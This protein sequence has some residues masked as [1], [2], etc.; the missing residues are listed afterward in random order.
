MFLELNDNLYIYIYIYI[1]IIYIYIY[2]VVCVEV[3]YIYIYIY[4]YIVP[5]R[6]QDVKYGQLLSGVN[7]FKFR[8]SSPRPVSIPKGAV[9]A[10]IYPLLEKE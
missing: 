8:L 5:P 9:Y 4:I 6:K 7:W 3:E 10:T 1:Y 2:I